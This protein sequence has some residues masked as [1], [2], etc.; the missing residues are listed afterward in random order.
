MGQTS[1]DQPVWIGPHNDPL[2]THAPKGRA[3]DG[4][5]RLISVIEADECKVQITWDSSFKLGKNQ[6]LKPEP[7]YITKSLRALKDHANTSRIR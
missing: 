7:S 1:I 6:K 3:M 2:K 5:Q 4:Y